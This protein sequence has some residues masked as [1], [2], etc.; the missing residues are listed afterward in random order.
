M[1]G[2]HTTFQGSHSITV[3]YQQFQHFSLGLFY[4]IFLCY[5]MLY[6]E[7]HHRLMVDGEG[8]KHEKENSKEAFQ[9]YC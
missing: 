8:K 4:R 3:F 1:N 5:T 2:P 6:D 7:K 9:D